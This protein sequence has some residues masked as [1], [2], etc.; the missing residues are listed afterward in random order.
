MQ[1]LPVCKR[2]QTL[3][4][5]WFSKASN[6]EGQTIQVFSVMGVVPKL[7]TTVAKSTATNSQ[8]HSEIFLEVLANSRTYSNGTLGISWR[9]YCD[10]GKFRNYWSNM[11]IGPFFLLC[12][13]VLWDTVTWRKTVVCELADSTYRSAA[14][15][16]ITGI[17][18]F[19][20]ISKKTGIPEKQ[21]HHTRISSHKCFQLFYYVE[22]TCAL[23]CEQA[24]T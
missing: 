2:M 15:L 7:C 16:I 21:Q 11:W 5:A 9:N 18:A 12:I 1:T 6:P 13:C 17:F 19:S 8:G 22:K 3:P 23:M 10:Q 14:I 20:V 24:R 4:L